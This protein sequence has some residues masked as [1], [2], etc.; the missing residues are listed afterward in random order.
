MSKNED[1]LQEAK[2]CKRDR[3]DFAFKERVAI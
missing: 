1:G 3:R 2:Q